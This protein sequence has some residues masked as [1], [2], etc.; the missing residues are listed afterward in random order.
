[1]LASRA[2]TQK[3]PKI[4][5][6]NERRQ[7]QQTQKKKSG[8]DWANKE[9]D[10]FLFLSMWKVLLN[11]S[12]STNP[13]Y[14]NLSKKDSRTFASYECSPS[15]KWSLQC[16]LSGSLICRLCGKDT[17]SPQF[18][19]RSETC[20]DRASAL[21]RFL[22]RPLALH[23]RNGEN[24]FCWKRNGTKELLGWFCYVHYFV[25]MRTNKSSDECCAGTC[26]CVCVISCCDWQREHT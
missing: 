20:I 8:I 19:R 18:L 3:R 25:F 23:R 26:V 12:A 16:L 2:H 6:W 17:Y 13:V 5:N 14:V 24:I 21:A 22:S 15:N 7:R 9:N 11:F 1:M 10:D 4:K